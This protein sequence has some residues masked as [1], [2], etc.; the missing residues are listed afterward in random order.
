MIKKK[1]LQY[2]GGEK[3]MANLV[4]TKCNKKVKEVI[5]PVY[6]HERGIPLKNVKAFQCPK[7]NEFVFDEKQVE[8]IEKRTETIKVHKF[9]FE[10]KLTVSG[11]S[12]VI[13]LPEDIVRHMKLSKG[14]KARLIPLDD[15]KLLLEVV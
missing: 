15:K 7:C 6:E 1:L 2:I 3:N 4:C 14:V 5:L 13:N 8:E 10:R 9:A 12:L 11:R